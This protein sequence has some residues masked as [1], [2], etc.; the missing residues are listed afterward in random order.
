MHALE[1]RLRRATLSERTRRRAARSA[2]AGPVRLGDGYRSRE[3]ATVCEARVRARGAGTVTITLGGW[4]MRWRSPADAGAPAW[5]STSRPLHLDLDA[6]KLDRGV[7][8]RV[9]RSVI[10]LARPLLLDAVG[11]DRRPLAADHQQLHYNYSSTSKSA[12]R[13][14]ACAT[15]S[16]GR[17]GC[18][19][20]RGLHQPLPLQG[21]GAQG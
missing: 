8:G 15:P 18:A 20:R 17:R 4:Q 5:C 11:P 14:S 13:L 3:G 2:R 10:R 6:R 1:A 19:A 9:P 21:Q 7:P 12:T 16:G